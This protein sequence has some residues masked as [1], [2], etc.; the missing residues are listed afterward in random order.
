MTTS[1]TPAGIPGVDY[2]I[3]A[4]DGVAAAGSD[5]FLAD[6]GHKNPAEHRAKVL[7]ADDIRL[8]IQ[9]QGLSQAD[10]AA[11]AGMAQADISRIV[12]GL[13]RGYSVWKLVKALNDLGAVTEIVVRLPKGETHA[14]AVG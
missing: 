8:L 12:R 4:V 7:L 6:R 11:Q 5:C 10:A 13:V 14:I 9:A 3:T 2:E 1:R